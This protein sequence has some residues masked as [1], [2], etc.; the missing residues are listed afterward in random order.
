MNLY[1][2]KNI[3]DLPQLE[4]I[5]PGNFMVVENFNGT[6]KLDFDDFVIGPRN[7]S[8]ANQVFND[9][10][11]LSSYSISLSSTASTTISAL[12]STMLQSINTLDSQVLVLSAMATQTSTVD[13]STAITGPMRILKGN[14]V[15]DANSNTEEFSFNMP[16]NIGLPLQNSDISMVPGAVYPTSMDYIWHITSITVNSDNTTTYTVTIDTNSVENTVDRVFDYTVIT[17]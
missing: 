4:Q 17:V 5:L 13:N 1:N 14:V 16:T 11:S 7:T 15:V 12:S 9:I 10:V 6:N 3:K 8:F 2:I